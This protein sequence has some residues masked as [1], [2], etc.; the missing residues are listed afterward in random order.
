MPT[1]STHSPEP[2]R[3]RTSPSPPTDRVVGVLELLA[4]RPGRAFSLSEIARSLG[5]N[6]ATC[7]AVATSLVTA[8]YLMR[9]P[10]DKT[11]T[12]GPALVAAGRAAE[13]EYPAVRLARA[14]VG[15]LTEALRL[16]TSAALRSEE[17]L[18]IVAHANGG[19]ETG[20]LRIGRRIPLAPPFGGV[21]VAW[22]GPLAAEEW[23]ARTGRPPLRERLLDSLAAIRQRGYSV[24]RLTPAA[25]Q[26]R[27][28]LEELS[29]DLLAG[30][31]Q[32]MV[33][34]L[35]A[36]LRQ[37]E[38][39]VEDLRPGARFPVSAMSAPV[40]DAQGRTQ[41]NLSVLPHRDMTVREIERT[42]RRLRRSCA[43]ITHAVAGR[44]PKGY[45]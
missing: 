27:Q 14:E 38:Y 37:D 42:G 41:M 36:E 29:D 12:L 20:A 15:A 11:F 26:L 16:P 28:A 23:A 30:D 8:D 7:H 3:A 6:K 13:Q 31:L 2:R 25:L 9:D 45:C 39:L 35:L 17:H 1:V 21:F 4:G 43:R 19:A 32:P 10:T 22:A 40:F 18:V 24:E 5:I 44:F 34:A 33:M